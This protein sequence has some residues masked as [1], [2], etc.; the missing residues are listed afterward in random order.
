VLWA[1]AR[2]AGEVVGV[3]GDAALVELARQNARENGI[4]NASFVMAD[5]SV[6]AG[7][8]LRR[9][10]PRIVLDPPRSGALPALKALDLSETSVIVYVSC[11]PATLARDAGFLASERGFRLAKAGIVDMFPHTSHVES[12]AVFERQ[13]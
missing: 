3:E 5:L 10:F 9:R 8:F 6:P 2:C 4:G 1:L 11:N 13:P 7:D 12:V